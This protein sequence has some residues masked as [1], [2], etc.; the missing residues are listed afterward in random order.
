M[1]MFLVF[2]PMLAEQVHQSLTSMGKGVGET[3]LRVV[4]LIGKALG[5]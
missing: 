4:D 2:E 1:T 5:S 3:T